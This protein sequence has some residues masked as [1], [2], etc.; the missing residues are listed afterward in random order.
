MQYRAIVQNMC[1]S[2][3]RTK[4]NTT[5]KKKRVTVTSDSGWEKN[6]KVVKDTN[7]WLL[8]E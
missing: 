8:G 2:F 3:I 7:L 1:T 5:G 6:V 4:T